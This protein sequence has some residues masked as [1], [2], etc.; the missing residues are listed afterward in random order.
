MAVQDP[1]TL[2]VECDGCG[3]TADMDTTEYCGDPSSWGVDD[4]TLEDN[5]WSRGD[6]DETFCPDCSEDEDEE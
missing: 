5:D 6:G 4:Q 1:G 3:K 2:T